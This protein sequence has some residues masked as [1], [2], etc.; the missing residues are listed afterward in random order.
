MCGIFSTIVL[1]K[2]C[3]REGMRER[4]RNKNTRVPTFLTKNAL[5]DS[6]RAQCS[7]ALVV[8]RFRPRREVSKDATIIF[9][10][11]FNCLFSYFYLRCAILI[12]LFVFFFHHSFNYFWKLSRTKWEITAHIGWE[13]R[14]DFFVGFFIVH[15][16]RCL[17]W[18]VN[19]EGSPYE[20]SNVGSVHF[21]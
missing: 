19:L 3:D 7:R 15:M 18:R 1:Q 13:E 21:L 8:K 20:N 9:I 2:Y 14:R 17:I 16:T 5:C 12:C 4:E 10:Y 6:Y 11:F